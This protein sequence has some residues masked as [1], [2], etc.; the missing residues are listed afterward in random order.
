MNKYYDKI[1][2]EYDKIYSDPISIAE[3]QIV[4]DFIN[5]NVGSKN[6][7][8]KILDIG[9]GT[10]LMLEL[11]EKYAPRA[12]YY[13]GIDISKKMLEKL[14]KKR[15]GGKLRWNQFAQI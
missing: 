7:I 12:E 10:G 11:Y 2:K 3:N 6:K 14:N 4:L 5:E 1:A 9:C 13:C 15:L 8:K